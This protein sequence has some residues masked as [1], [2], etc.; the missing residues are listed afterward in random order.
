MA[1]LEPNNYAVL[2][3]NAANIEKA[4]KL[5]KDKVNKT[6][7]KE[8]ENS[9]KIAPTNPKSTQISKTPQVSNILSISNNA[10]LSY[11][12]TTTLTSISNK[13][14]NNRDRVRN[15]LFKIC[16]QQTPNQQS[17]NSIM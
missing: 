16:T 3:S 2:K 15:D 9:Q 14:L 4:E 8:K 6:A 12:Q 11:A 1:Y 17:V 5:I 10:S 13:P 7:S